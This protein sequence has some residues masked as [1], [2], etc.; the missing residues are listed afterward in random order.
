M[1]DSRGVWKKTIYL[2]RKK[3]HALE[4]YNDSDVWTVRERSKPPWYL[5]HRLTYAILFFYSYLHI[6]TV[7]Y[8]LHTF[9]HFENINKPNTKL[10]QL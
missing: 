6:V 1:L 7:I 4:H 9:L 5:R 3:N 10:I 2:Q 8:L